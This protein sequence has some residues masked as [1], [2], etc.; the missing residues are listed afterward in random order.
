MHILL[1][2][3]P[4]RR[5]KHIKTASKD[6][7]IAEVRRSSSYVI[8]YGSII[9]HR[10]LNFIMLSTWTP[11]TLSRFC[12]FFLFYFLH[13]RVHFFVLF[14]RSANKRDEWTVVSSPWMP[15]ISHFA[16]QYQQHVRIKIRERIQYICVYCIV[17]SSLLE[18][19]FFFSFLVETKNSNSPPG[20]V[21]LPTHTTHDRRCTL[22]EAQIHCT[23]S[24]NVHVSA[25]SQAQQDVVWFVTNYLRP[26]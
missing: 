6:D 8:C 24:T 16:R 21:C 12:Y 26:L 13:G 14:R 25:K 9:A 19:F 15:A 17:Y 23:P 20:D 3:S 11:H 1:W 5:Q 2:K 22:L 4:D 7:G 18:Y 10:T